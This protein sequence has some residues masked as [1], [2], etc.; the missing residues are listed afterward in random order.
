MSK[1]GATLPEKLKA[2]RDAGFG[3]IELAMSDLLAY[4]KELYSEEPNAYDFDT[5]TEV[6]KAVNILASKYDLKILLLKPFS[7]FEGWKKYE[8][9]TEREDAFT[10]ARG[11]IRVME[12]VGTDMLQVS[13]PSLETSII[14]SIVNGINMDE[15]CVLRMRKES[16]HHLMI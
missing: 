15:R 5:L 3:A 16:P 10:R 13:Q 1:S 11:W 2:I 6:A 4:G 7:K 12:A 8:S 9:T 14:I